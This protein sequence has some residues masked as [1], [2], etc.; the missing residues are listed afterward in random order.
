MNCLFLP[1]RLWCNPFPYHADLTNT[2][3]GE[4]WAR[5]GSGVRVLR[6][7]WHQLKPIELGVEF[8][9]CDK[10][11][12]GP[13]TLSLPHLSHSWTTEGTGCG[14]GTQLVFGE[15]YVFDHGVRCTVAPKYYK[16]FRG[17]PACALPF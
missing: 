10:Y 12:R 9:S 13:S 8:L 6:I 14:I 4:G 2:S 3:F 5:P 17:V 11:L 15:V 1:R 7:G 16:R